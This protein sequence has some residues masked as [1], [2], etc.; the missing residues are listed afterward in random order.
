IL[1]SGRISSEILVK[2]VK[3]DVPVIISRN[4]PTSLSVNLAL[5]LGIT[6]VG[7]VRGGRLNVYTHKDR[8]L[9]NNGKSS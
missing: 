7:F 9:A 2:A 3:R 5:H 4:A 1:T 6:I 8:I